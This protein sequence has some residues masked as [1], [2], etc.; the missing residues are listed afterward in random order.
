MK[1]ILTLP[2]VKEA[3]LYELLKEG[4]VRCGLCERR[5][6]ILPGKRGFCKTRLNIEG[7]LYTLVYGDIS[8]I[9]EA[10]H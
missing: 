2:T 9:L 5:C 1:E 7:K 6:I 3:I 10:V 4:K 8:S